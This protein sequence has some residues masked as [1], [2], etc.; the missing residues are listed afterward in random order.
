MDRAAPP[1]WRWGVLGFRR[2]PAKGNHQRG[3]VAAS[4]F[5]K[6]VWLQPS[7]EGVCGCILVF[8][9][10]LHVQLLCIPE[11]SMMEPCRLVG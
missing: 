1:G 8:M 11:G 4:L 5:L 3:G 7:L 10:T 6:G 2:V 9:H